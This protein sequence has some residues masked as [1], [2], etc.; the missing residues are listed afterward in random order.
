MSLRVSRKKILFFSFFCLAVG[1]RIFVSRMGFNFDYG[2]WR[3]V[4]TI[5][6]Q[7]KNVF[8]E[9]TRY[10]YGPIWAIILGIFKKV[11]LLFYNNWF[12]FRLLIIFSLSLA[13]IAITLLLY[14]YIGY[15]AFFWFLFNPVSIY[16]SGFHNQFDNISIAIALY[17]FKIIE[18]YRSRLK[19]YFILGLS[20]A[21]KH[22]FL[23]FPLWLF[24]S[25]KNRKQRL[26]SF[27]PYLVFFISFIPFSFSQ[28]AFLGI[29]NNVFMSQRDLLYAFLPKTFFMTPL[30]ILFLIIPFGFLLRK[31]KITQ[32]GF[33]YLLVFMM[34]LTN[35][36]SQYL[37][38]PLVSYAVLDPLVGILFTT[39]ALQNII[40]HTLK[41][42][43]TLILAFQLSW[44]I[45][46][47]KYLPLFDKSIR[48]I[49]FVFLVILMAKTFPVFF[50]LGKEIL[51]TERKNLWFM[52]SL[53]PASR[54]FSY[55]GEKSKKALTSGVVIKG[56]F[57]A[58]QNNLGY[59]TIPFLTD[60]TSE[61]F[62][63]KHYTVSAKIKEVKNSGNSY[64]ETRDLSI[65][66]TGEGILLGFPIISDS[67]GKEYEVSIFTDIPT[68]ENY[69]TIDLT[70]NVQ[71]RY[72]LSRSHLNS[73][74]KI[75]QFAYNKI[76]YFLHQTAYISFLS[77]L[78]CY[79]WLTGA[80]FFL[81]KKLTC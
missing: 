37:A 76:N 35:S 27:I 3:D 57:I 20:F 77:Q 13:D 24:F 74:D 46:I 75:T 2:S 62:L 52:Q 10:S 15:F 53:E 25:S 68:R 8:A 69:L 17:S 28:K 5:V 60:R 12:V 47:K 70:G 81:K 55:S 29:I 80:L 71:V 49:C 32:Q 39:V 11:S 50:T 58:K 14:E 61:N 33:Y 36:G 9:T 43:T 22:V 18:K 73:L 78:Y 40:F 41:L 1:L 42:Q 64:Q 51:T 48:I 63:E 26:L 16:T 54:V 56:R 21:V 6:A 7:G 4:G 44:L 67:L 45:F 38:I 34:V 23:F 72:F 19:G 65:G 79:L 31:E 59:V 66:L 30:I